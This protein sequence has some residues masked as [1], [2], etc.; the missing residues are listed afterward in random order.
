MNGKAVVAMAGTA[1]LGGVAGTMLAQQPVQAQMPASGAIHVAA[2]T[3]GTT[4]HAWAVDPRTSLV[5]HCVAT[6]PT[7]ASFTCQSAALPGM[8]AP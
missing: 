5:I 7:S 6:Q 1:L 3:V 4:S 8:G 2:T